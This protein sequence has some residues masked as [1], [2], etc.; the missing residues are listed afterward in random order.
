MLASGVGM[1]LDKVGR[2]GTGGG[3]THSEAYYGVEGQAARGVQHERAL[4][5]HTGQGLGLDTGGAPQ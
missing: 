1:L 3:L 2:P 4:H 5:V